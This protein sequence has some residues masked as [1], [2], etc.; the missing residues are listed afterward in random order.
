VSH[1]ALNIEGGVIATYAPSKTRMLAVGAAF[2]SGVWVQV[3]FNAFEYDIANDADLVNNRFVARYLGYH[4]VTGSIG[5]S[6]FPVA[7]T[8][9]QIQIRK[10][11]ATR[12]RTRTQRAGVPT[13]T[14]IIHIA[15]IIHLN[16][17]DFVDLWGLHNAGAGITMNAATSRTY[18]CVMGPLA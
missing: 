12:V 18:M 13:G 11:G 10:N 16:P 7:A 2:A 14:L 8:E 15:D 5:A 17:G 9:Y 4:I 3:D 1:K 6:G